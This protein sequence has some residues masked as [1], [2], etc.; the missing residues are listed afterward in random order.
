[1]GLLVAT[2]GGCGARIRTARPETARAKACP[3]CNM[4]LASAIAQ[5]LAKARQVVEDQS[6]SVL[7]ATATETAA[8][9][10]LVDTT[11]RA[12]EQCEDR[13]VHFMVVFQAAMAAVLLVTALAFGVAALRPNGAHQT[14]TR[15]S[16]H[17]T[18]T[19]PPPAPIPSV[20]RPASKSEIPP[21][22]AP[23]AADL[24][25]PP[26][27]P[28]VLS[29]RSEPPPPAT[30]VAAV[31][32]TTSTS[33][34]S[35]VDSPPAPILPRVV[36]VSPPPPATPEVSTD[37]GEVMRPSASSSEPRRILVRDDTGRPV[38]TRVYGEQDDQIVV[39]LPDGQLGW[40]DG[41]SYTDRPFRPA[42]AEEMRETLLNGPY[43]GFQFRQT[44]HYLIFYQCS[45]R[46][47]ADSANLLETLY[48]GLYSKLG[49]DWGLEVHEAEFPLVA[50][51][52]DTERAF[53]AHTKVAPDV[54]AFYHIHSNR[55]FFFER[56]EKERT[57]P[58]I[59]LIRQPQTIAHEGTHQILLNIGVQPR[60]AKWPIWLVEGL[61]EYW[62]PTTTKRGAE[63]AGG[64]LVNPLHMATIRD[65]Q[66]QADL[67]RRFGGDA[68]ARVPRSPLVEELA[69]KTELTPTDYATAWALTHF[70]VAKRFDEFIAYL[71]KMSKMSPME[72]PTPDEQLKTFRGSFVLDLAKL[73][74]AIAKY[75][76][77]L[78][79]YDP[80]PYYAVK[81][82]QPVGGGVKRAALVS[83]SPSMIYQWIDEMQSPQGGLPSWEATPFPTKTRALAEAGDWM[84]PR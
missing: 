28:P 84:S 54:Q 58:E 25:P 66:D 43:H 46:F 18:P 32:S 6:A 50:V 1:M 69:R 77:T 63:W 67:R 44:Q 52:Y 20:A 26:P 41:M 70:L 45:D 47:A 3:L 12:L 82:L 51:I 7:T 14:P 33:P 35:G 75:L 19:P 61:A 60:L 36:G 21:A 53:R 24:P 49:A 39:L 29:I 72:R 13:S 9:A 78:K 37:P 16:S 22:P 38:V 79:K 5:A 74:K 48:K 40:I 71:K 81:F 68:A 64:G 10:L 57:N 42:T 31:A 83:Q 8:P 80:L 11:P 15:L 62:A 30:D 73:D 27:A 4:P 59:A 23:S 2:C 17:S 65:L 56:S 55:I 34:P 76:G